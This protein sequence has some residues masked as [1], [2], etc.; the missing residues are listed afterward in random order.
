LIPK[1]ISFSPIFYHNLN[2][3]SFQE[4]NDMQFFMAEYMPA[5]IYFEKMKID[6]L[7]VFY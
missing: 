1:C 5:Y 7:E 4:N 2:H 3:H 6:I